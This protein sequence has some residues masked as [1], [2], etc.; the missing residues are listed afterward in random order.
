MAA[1]GRP[2]KLK[3]EAIDR[4]AELVQ[5]GCPD[6]GIARELG[7]HAV[8]FARW[9]AKARNAKR[10][11]WCSLWR[12]YQG[13]ERIWAM[14]RAR[15]WEAVQLEMQRDN[16]I[17]NA[18][19]HYDKNGR[20]TGTTVRLEQRLTRECAKRFE[21]NPFGVSLPDLEW[22]HDYE[23]LMPNRIPMPEG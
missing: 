2:T 14:K 10:G 3:P 21:E 13:G 11:I 20:L 19:Y 12:R 5:E 17:A 15:I 18:E 22:E 1:T 8:T 16:A 4:I 7:I 6:A 23:S 9:K